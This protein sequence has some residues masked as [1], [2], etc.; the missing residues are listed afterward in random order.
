MAEGEDTIEYRGQEY[1]VEQVETLFARYLK[2]GF[3]VLI[4][5]AAF[6][7]IA[8]GDFWNAYG[9]LAVGLT[10]YYLGRALWMIA[11]ADELKDEDEVEE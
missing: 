10:L 9:I 2:T 4:G 11:L 8:T 6:Y 7:H 1:T 5:S 3:T